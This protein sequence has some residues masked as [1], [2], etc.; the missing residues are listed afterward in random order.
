MFNFFSKKDSQRSH[1]VSLESKDPTE[2]DDSF[3]SLVRSYSE[4]PGVFQGHKAARLELH[5]HDGRAIDYRFQA[6]TWDARYR[7]GERAICATDPTH[8]PPVD[9]CTCGFYALSD[10][11]EIWGNRFAG[12]RKGISTQI[13]DVQFSGEVIEGTR[14]FRAGTQH[15]LDVKFRPICSQKLCNNHAD[16][17]GIDVTRPVTGEQ[18]WF[19]ASATCNKHADR[20]I[21]MSLNELTTLVG[22]DVSIVE[23]EPDPTV[24]ATAV[25][26]LQRKK[27]NWIGLISLMAFLIVSTIWAL[28]AYYHND[29]SI[30]DTLT[31]GTT[32]FAVLSG[33]TLFYVWWIA[34]KNPTGVQ[35]V[36]F[37]MLVGFWILLAFID[38]TSL[39][40]TTGK[41]QT[42]S[43]NFETTQAT[44]E[45]LELIADMYNFK[46]N[47]WESTLAMVLAQRSGTG[48]PTIVENDVQPGEIGVAVED[49]VAHMVTHGSMKSI[50]DECY[51]IAVIAD[52]G[53]DYYSKAVIR[54]GFSFADENG[55]QLDTE[56]IAWEAPK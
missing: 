53:D 6:I 48:L 35:S 50:T 2:S 45:D 3:E 38:I 49:N 31:S 12:A 47:Q 11:T 4:S 25:F 22:V 18:D 13:L 51:H 39:V 5:W 42:T 14:G 23:K 19:Y 20:L 7:I 55:C 34:R 17:V 27:M 8:V 52:P 28:G 24:Q 15:I 44:R 21:E 33:S 9:G 29:M 46:D 10:A 37:I 1:A 32:T 16:V 54:Y 26:R 56:N 41:I 36:L 40:L 43:E 30:S